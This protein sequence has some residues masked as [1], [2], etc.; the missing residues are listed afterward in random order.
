MVEW[1][2]YCFTGD[3]Q[4]FFTQ[5]MYHTNKYNRF[6]FDKITVRIVSNKIICVLLAVRFFGKQKI[7]LGDI[8]WVLPRF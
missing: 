3:Y 7:V 1:R 8:Y 6:F 2:I 5:H 4:I